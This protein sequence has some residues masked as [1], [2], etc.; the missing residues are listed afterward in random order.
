MREAKPWRKFLMSCQNNIMMCQCGGGG[1]VESQL[2]MERGRVELAG[3]VSWFSPVSHDWQSTYFRLFVLSVALITR[4][5]ETESEA[6]WQNLR[7]A[8]THLHTT[9]NVN[10]NLMKWRPHVFFKMFSVEF[11]IS[12]DK[13][14]LNKRE[15]GAQLRFHLSL[16]SSSTPLRT[17]VLL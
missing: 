3:N 14:S 10:L 16:E 1:V 5:R 2:W 15:P 6:T 12:A 17:G 13:R 4:E 7:D 11:W 9:R 8:L